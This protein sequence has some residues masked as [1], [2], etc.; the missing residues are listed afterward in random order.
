MEGEG[1]G[2]T[3]DTSTL[4]DG[5]ANGWRVAR[6]ERADPSRQVDAAATFDNRPDHLGARD[7]CLGILVGAFVLPADAGGRP[8]DADGSR[9]PIGDRLATRTDRTAFVGRG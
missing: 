1:E 9:T 7:L 6:G 5:Y 2:K 3:L 4:V 8:S